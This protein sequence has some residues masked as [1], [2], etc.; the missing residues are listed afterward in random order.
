MNEPNNSLAEALAAILKPI[1][2]D[3]VKEAI[4]GHKDEDR[5]V[6]AEDAALAA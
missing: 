1:V 2:Q 6:D 4:D 5:L 3:A